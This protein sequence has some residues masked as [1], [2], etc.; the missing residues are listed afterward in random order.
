[1]AYGNPA[2]E[3]ESAKHAAACS[4]RDF[5]F[6]YL[7][8]ED[9]KLLIQKCT[10]CGVLRNPPGPC[11]AACHSLAWTTVESTGLGTIF[12]YTFHHH[13]PVP[14]FTVPHAIVVVDMNEG[15]RMVGGMDS[16]GKAPTIG[17]RVRAEFSRQGDLASFCFV[18]E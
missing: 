16:S 1:M 9:N 7:G 12:T 4:N 18:S 2:I 13:P 14:G 8:L 17:T 5:D 11:C 3:G 6:F 10:R 15:I